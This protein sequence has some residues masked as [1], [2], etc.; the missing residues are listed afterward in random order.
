MGKNISEMMKMGDDLQDYISDE[1]ID[2]IKEK[3]PK[4]KNWDMGEYGYD[5]LKSWANLPYEDRAIDFA[6]ENPFQAGWVELTDEDIDN[7]MGKVNV[8]RFSWK[9]KKDDSVVVSKLRC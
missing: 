9:V 2:L 6:Y 8:V 1:V 3:Y 5:K 7:K 4:F